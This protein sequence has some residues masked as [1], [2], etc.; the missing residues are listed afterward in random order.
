MA[1]NGPSDDPAFVGCCCKLGQLAI[2]LSSNGS[3]ANLFCPPNSHPARAPFRTSIPELAIRCVSDRWSHRTCCSQPNRHH[4]HRKGPLASSF[5]SSSHHRR[6]SRL[7]KLR[8]TESERHRPGGR[9][10][11]CWLTA[12]A[13][14]GNDDDDDDNHHHDGQTGSVCCCYDCA[15]GESGLGLSC[16]V[17]K[18]TMSGSQAMPA[19]HEHRQWLALSNCHCQAGQRLR[20]GGCGLWWR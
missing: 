20:L 2:P 12:V 1:H 18:K 11:L 17:T 9:V 13:E 5:S 19:A 15:T 8:L 14:S 10:A 7:D 6:R 3:G 16:Q 4:S